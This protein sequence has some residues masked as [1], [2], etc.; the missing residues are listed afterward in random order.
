MGFTC[1]V[2]ARLELRIDLKNNQ[3]IKIP[4]S[5]KKFYQPV[6]IAQ[7]DFRA[8]ESY[9][10]T[11][12]RQMTLR[13]HGE[14]PSFSSGNAEP[15]IR[16]SSF[17]LWRRE[18]GEFLLDAKELVP[19]RMCLVQPD[20]SQG[21]LYMDF[22]ESNDSLY[23]PEGLEIRLFSTWLASLGDIILHAS[24]IKVG[25]DG[26][27]F[28]GESGAGK[29][30]LVKSLAGNPGTVVLGEDQ[31]ILRYL[32]GEF[33][34]FGTPW[35]LNPDLCSPEG[36]KLKKMYFLDRSLPPGT[37]RI[38]SITGVTNLLKT[39]VI[40]YYHTEWLSGILDRLAILPENVPFYSFSFQ[41]ETDALAQI[42]QA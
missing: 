35:H 5:H 30:T 22:D 20:F 21:D 40:P 4:S 11:L 6:E 39:A 17:D 36:V 41:L 18:S 8:D 23:P 38:S 25:E 24:G 33:W 27:C 3:Q 26:Y 14:N 34:I 7:A 9:Q 16:S 31:V 2:I 29:S 15:L 42:M 12:S 1:F 19:R 28:L 37:Q 32:D 13:V 10:D